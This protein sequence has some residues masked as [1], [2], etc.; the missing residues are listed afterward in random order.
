MALLSNQVFWPKESTKTPSWLR[1]MLGV[2]LIVVGILVLGDV[3]TATLISAAAIGILAM[4]GGAIEIG[5]AFSTKG[6]G[7]FLWQVPLGLLYIG[8]GVIV[9]RQ[10]LFGALVLTLVMGLL[11]VVS[12]IL[13]L[14]L[15]FNHWADAGLPMLVSGA[16]GILAGV[17]ILTGFPTSG[18][19]VLG[20][21]LGV[22]LILHGL[23]W[24]AYGWMPRSRDH[25]GGLGRAS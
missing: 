18:L 24:L 17:V 3:L 8:F 21:V 2:G 7:G 13:R 9:L 6:S 11:F 23:A 1:M 19:W 4:I 12:G 15:S 22:D 25:L 10:P 20:L 5:E 14:V 16:F